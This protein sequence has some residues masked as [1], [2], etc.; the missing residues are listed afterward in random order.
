MAK[1]LAGVKGINNL[2]PN[3]F[4]KIWKM[5]IIST[6]LIKTTIIKKFRLLL[7]FTKGKETK[8]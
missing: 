3:M 8:N 5:N 6:E 7:N 1:F 4:S 2:A